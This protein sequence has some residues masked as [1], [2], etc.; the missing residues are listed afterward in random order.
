MSKSSLIN[1]VKD[2]FFNDKSAPTLQQLWVGGK[3]IQ[4][5][6]IVNDRLAVI[7]KQASEKC[8]KDSYLINNEPKSLEMF[9]SISVNYDVV[10]A[11]GF[12]A[13]DRFAVI[14]LDEVLELQKQRKRHDS[15]KQ[16][17]IKIEIT[18]KRGF[19]YYVADGAKLNQAGK[20]SK[21]TGLITK[22]VRNLM[23]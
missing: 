8:T 21:S 16:L 10:F 22:E 7:A 11:C 19:C 15:T 13:D 9:K 23:R 1:L 12:T 18:S 3:H 4:N 20:Q 17:P 6:I 2:E 5:G 14:T